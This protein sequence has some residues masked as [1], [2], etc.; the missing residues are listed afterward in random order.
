MKERKNFA[1]LEFNG[2]GSVPNHIYTGT[3]TLWGAYKEILMHW[4]AM[5]EISA[6]NRRKGIAYY[7][8]LQG[9]RFLQHSKKHFRVLKK[10][11]KEL[12]V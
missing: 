1:I 7:S 4:K 10:L 2:A 3:Y 5:Y 8:L 9:H 6:A 11:D 12:V